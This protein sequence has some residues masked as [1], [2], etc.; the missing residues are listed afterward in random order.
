MA[1][2]RKTV[3]TG[4]T[5]ATA[6]TLTAYSNVCVNGKILRIDYTKTDFSDGS[7]MTI[8][9]A[10]SGV[11][12]W[13]ETGVN[14]S[15]TRYPRAQCHST[16]GVALTYDNTR[17]VCEPIPINDEFLQIFVSGAGNSKVGTWTIY[18]E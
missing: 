9:G 1:F 6:G 5:H 14:A 8:T 11:A 16:A 17:T 2:I 13:T 15:A 12:I 10:T 3:I 7:V 18:Y 4:T